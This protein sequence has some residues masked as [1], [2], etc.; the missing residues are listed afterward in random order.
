MSESAVARELI[1]SHVSDL[2]VKDVKI[3]EDPIVLAKYDLLPKYVC[4]ATATRLKDPHHDPMYDKI[5]LDKW[6][7]RDAGTNRYGETPEIVFYRAAT[8]AADGLVANDNSLDKETLVR[9]IFDKFAAR[10]IFPNT[11]YMANGGHSLLADDLEAR[12]D[13]S[14]NPEQHTVLAA[15]LEQERK[16]R[17]QLFACFVLGIYDSRH[18]I[19]TTLG[20]AADIQA[21]VGGTGFNW[22]QLRPGLEPI[23]GTGGITDGPVSFMGMYSVALGTTI[24]QGG[25]RDGANMFMLDANH[26]DI[27]RFIYAKREDG[28][29]PASNMSVAIDHDFMEATQQEGEGRFYRLKNPHYNPEE[30]PHLPEF[31]SVDQL[32]QGLDFASSNKKARA[33]MLLSEDGTEILSPWLHE[34]MD[35]SYQVIGKVGKDGSILLDSHKILGHLSYSAWFNGEPGMIFTGTINDV[36]PVHPKYYAKALLEDRVATGQIQKISEL[37]GKGV[38]LEDAVDFYVNEVDSEGKPVNLPVGIGIIRATNPCG[39]KPLLPREACVLGHLNLEKLVIT[40]PTNPTGYRFD[41]D[42]LEENTKLMYEILDNA[43]DQNQFTNPEIEE[44]QKS[45]RKIGLGFMGLANTLMKLELAYDS[46]EGREFVGRIL[47]RWEEIS[48]QS[49]REKAEKLGSYPNFRYSQHRNGP[50]KR[51]AIVRTIAPTG[52]TGFLAQTTGGLEPE[53]ALFY[54]RET[55][56]GSEINVRNRILEEKVEK[57]DIL[58][59][60]EE[61]DRFFGFI[62]NPRG[63]KGTIQGF[64]ITK[65]PGETGEEFS[66]RQGRLDALKRIFV[67]T[68]DVDPRDHL[69]MQSTVQERVDDAISKT[70]NLRN[71]V[72]FGDIGEI[73]REAYGMGLKG[74]TIYRDGTRKGQPLKVSKDSVGEPQGIEVEDVYH[75]LV[76]LVAQRLSEPR[77]HVEG[78]TE[79]V[80]TPLGSLFLTFNFEE[81]G[82]PYENFYKIGKSGEDVGSIVEALGRAVSQG[83]KSGV[84]PWE[85]VDQF[86]GIGGHSQAGFGPD[87]VL[88]VPDAIGRAMRKILE[89]RGIERGGKTNS[90]R[91]SNNGSGNFC[92]ECRKQLHMQEGCE[93]CTCGWSKC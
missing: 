40:D 64:E 55:V 41:W 15:D 72:P 18:S 60:G 44:V 2:N 93:K 16:V 91:S 35:R 22:S 65:A 78:P 19:F 30:R 58:R 86:E 79:K 26:P 27:M 57:Y 49:S 46:E 69:M 82:H 68:Y 54:I 51:N 36:N 75:M 34:G 74:L 43:I 81:N 21:S 80:E 76:P 67:T 20:E 73:V 63:G 37:V 33:S 5:F 32:K 7:R 17:E 59:T 31:Y 29:I 42:K 28:E 53:Y 11:P 45:N 85:Y 23:A 47:D 52:T 89:E 14:E 25:K 8:L 88:S 12:I 24:N 10:E 48:E 87:K 83:V 39:E 90:S 4:E 61:K 13:S 56:Q 84:D 9:G 3:Y 70:T 71:N 6:G 92:P 62:E 38:S 1:K 77:P 50:P 66:A